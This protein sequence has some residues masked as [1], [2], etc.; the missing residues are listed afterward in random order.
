MWANVWTPT[1]DFR[2]L[3]LPKSKVKAVYTFLNGP[4]VP[5]GEPLFIVSSKRPEIVFSLHVVV[6]LLLCTGIG[7][8]FIPPSDDDVLRADN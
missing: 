5:Q 6:D 7:G 2:A 4:L 8:C 3:A 1:G